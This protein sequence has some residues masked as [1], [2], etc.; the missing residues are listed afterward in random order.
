MNFS[1]GWNKV[2]STTGDNHGWL[3]REESLSSSLNIIRG[4]S[5]DLV[6]VLVEGEVSV[7]KEVLGDFFKSI[8]L[9]FESLEDVHLKLVLGS[10]KFFISNSFLESAQFFKS[11]REEILGVRSSSSDGDTE[12]S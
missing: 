10:N 12:E 1:D 3:G 9:S 8:L 11:D 5:V 6:N 2:N 7:S 4:N